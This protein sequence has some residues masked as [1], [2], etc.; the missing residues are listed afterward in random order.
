M[1]LPSW[2]DSGHAGK[3][4]SGVVE[5]CWS[6]GHGRQPCACGWQRWRAFN[7][8][9]G[10]IHVTTLELT[11]NRQIVQAWPTSEFPEDALDSHMDLSLEKVAEGT[12]L[13]L[14]H[15]N[16]PVLQIDSY[17]QVWGIFILS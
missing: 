2:G 1:D 12:K 10:Y 11:P 15:G 17:R 6:H 4:L 8:R 13:I 5:H 16:M 14:T 7:T 3:D 9:D